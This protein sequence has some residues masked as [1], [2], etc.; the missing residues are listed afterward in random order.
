MSSEVGFLH[1]ALTFWGLREWDLLKVIGRL[2]EYVK[3]IGGDLRVFVAVDGFLLDFTQLIVVE[4][5]LFFYALDF[6]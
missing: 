5:P 4:V 1:H 3:D 6:L 2:F